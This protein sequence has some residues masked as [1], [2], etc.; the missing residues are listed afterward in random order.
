MIYEIINNVPLAYTDSSATSSALAIPQNMVR[1][2]AT[3][4]CA[5]SINPASGTAATANDILLG[6]FQEILLNIPNGY[7]ISAIRIGSASGTLSIQAINIG[8]R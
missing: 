3:T 8:G 4:T 1:L 5:I 2:C 6:A 7:F